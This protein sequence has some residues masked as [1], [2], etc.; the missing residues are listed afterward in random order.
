VRCAVVAASW[1]SILAIAFPTSTLIEIRRLSPGMSSPYCG[2][3]RSQS[4]RSF[5]GVVSTVRGGGLPAVL[6]SLEPC[7]IRQSFSS[8]M[9]RKC[10]NTLPGLLSVS[11]CRAG[12]GLGIRACR[13]SLQ[14]EVWGLFVGGSGCGVRGSGFER[15]VEGWGWR[16]WC[17][18]VAEGHYFCLRNP[19]AYV[20]EMSLVL[21]HL[22]TRRTCVVN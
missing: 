7:R 12:W 1:R 17:E 10:A 21:I 19:I 5:P 20:F 13:G 16:V 22:G 15:R 18:E 2:S 8:S 9:M 14:M 4:V 6:A 11:T 3:T